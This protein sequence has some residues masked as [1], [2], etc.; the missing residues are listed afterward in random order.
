MTRRVRAKKLRREDLE[1]LSKEEVFAKLN[2]SA[3]RT[4][5]ALMKAYETGMEEGISDKEEDQVIELLRRAKK[6]RDAVKQLT[7]EPQNSDKRRAT[8]C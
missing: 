7:E 6:F 4:L 2:A 1:K 8:C 3:Q 5:D